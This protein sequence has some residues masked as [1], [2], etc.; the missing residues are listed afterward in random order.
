MQQY[1]GFHLN[2]GEYTIPILKVRE[3]VNTPVITRMPQSPDYIEGITNLRGAVIP[4]LNLKKLVRLGDS[5]DKGGKVI[6]VAS[7]RM[8]FGVL[9]DGITGVINIEETEIE[10]PESVLRDS[11]EQIEGVA[12]LNDRLVVLLDTKKLIPFEDASLFEDVVLDVQK[13]DEA[14]KVEVVKKR[15]T[16]AGYI[17][18]K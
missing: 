16:M 9:V 15:Q 13:T 4:I 17:R 1:I 2:A 5:G 12:R 14:N 18:L 7:G 10:H 3:I 6:V 11:R 8:T